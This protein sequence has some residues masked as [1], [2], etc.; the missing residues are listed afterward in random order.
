MKLKSI[1]WAAIVGAMLTAASARAEKASFSYMPADAS[2]IY[3]GDR[4][5]Q[6]Y[7]VAIHLVQP[8]FSGKKITGLSVPVPEGISA[9]GL[10]GWLSSELRLTDSNGLKVNDPDI[11]SANARMEKIGKTSMLVAEFAEP[12]MIPDGGV[13]V[14][15]TFTVDES[16]LEADTELPVA[17]CRGIDPEGFYMYA[18]LMGVKWKSLSEAR[19]FISALKVELDGEFPSYSVSLSMGDRDKFAMME[20][21]DLPVKLTNYTTNEISSITYAYTCG[22]ETGTNTI[23][24]NPA[25]NIQFG[26]SA[27]CDLPIDLS[28]PIGDYPV[29]IRIT[30]M[31][32]GENINSNS[33]IRPDIHILSMIP[34]NRP[35][36]EEFT[37][38]WCGWCPRGFA[39]MQMLEE[40]FGDLFVCASYHSDDV[41]AVYQDSEF[42]F[43]VAGYPAAYM[44][45][46][47]TMLDPFYGDDYDDIYKFAMYDYWVNLQKK[48]T[49][50]AVEASARWNGDN[51]EIES[52]ALNVEGAQGMYMMMYLVLADGLTGEGE[53]WEQQNKFSGDPGW[54]AYPSMEAFSKAGPLVSGLVY[55]DVV[56]GRSSVMGEFGSLPMMIEKDVEYPYTYTFDASNIVNLEG[57]PVIQNKDK[58]SVVACVMDASTMTVANCVKCHVEGAEGVSLSYGDLSEAVVTYYDLNGN[59]V[60]AAAKGLLIRRAVY[61][62]GKVQTVKIVR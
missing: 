56:V 15:Y 7:N 46:D 8:E 52:K 39:A 32:G 26:H 3:T 58:V 25:L 14:G 17:G 45:R 62:D 27:S 59:I 34:V 41:L 33:E 43:T 5:A 36:M 1:F 57:Q 29:S 35:L 40:S 9:E 13:Y 42:P 22:E 19:N 4:V 21:F 28:L 10:S 55:N 44:N 24:F 53:A 23:D 51:I 54:G 60:E 11:M 47:Q 16:G 2:T 30:E 37:G 31:N 18:S 20:P 48:Y 38:I 61:P 12:Y 6:T 49:P 50:W